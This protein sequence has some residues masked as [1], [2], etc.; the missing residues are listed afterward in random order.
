MNE[1]L[2]SPAP[3]RH[4]AR[5]TSRCARHTSWRAGGRARPRSTSRPTATTSRRSCAQLPRG[6]AGALCVGLGSNLLVRDGGV[7]GTV[8]VHAQPRRRAR[9]RATASI[10]AEAG[11]ASPKLARFAAKHGCAGAE[12]LAGIPGTVGGALAMNAGC[13]GG[14]T[15][16][17]VVRVEVLTR[18]GALRGAH[19]GR[20]RDRLPHACAAPTAR[21]R[22]GIFTAA[23]FRFPPGDATRRAA[24]IKELLARRIATQPLDAAQRRQRVPQSAG[25]PRGAADRGL[26]AQGLRDRRRAGVGEARELHRQPA[27]A[28]ARAADIEALI[29][30]VQRDGARRAPASTLEPEVRIVGE[31]GDEAHDARRI[32]QG[33]GAAG[34]P[35]GRAR[36]LAHV[37]QRGA[38][39]RCASKGVDAHAFDP[40]ERDLC[41]LKRDGFER[42]FIALH[43][44]FG[45]DGT[46]QGALETLGI[47]YTGSG[48]MASAL[49]MDKWRTKL[50]WLARGIPTPRYRV[51]D[52]A[53]DW[54]R[55]VARARAAADREAGARRLDASASPRCAR[56]TA[57]SSRL[58]YALAAKHDPLVLV[59]EFVAGHGA[60]RVDPRRR[61]RCR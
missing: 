36:D 48:V 46:V 54:T 53:T 6:R 20:L 23:W 29:A 9:G 26:R 57:T 5:T 17:H 3:A 50:V 27:A 14:E 13:Y 42:V 61:A 47:P 34:R 43:G 10:Y 12:F 55:V 40:A 15:W 52:A 60:H 56:S 35:V 39:A 11:V 21:R 28:R 51:V 1:P 38:R 31:R 33:R 49:A 7:R 32:R 16:S 30:H 4:A 58:A 18:D 2:A 19:A 41:E 25:R 37:R 8:V 45:E 24:R 44:R 22:D 59:E